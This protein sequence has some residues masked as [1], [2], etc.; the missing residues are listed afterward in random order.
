MAL[1][2]FL[3]WAVGPGPAVVIPLSDA[4]DGSCPLAWDRGVTAPVPAVPLAPSGGYLSPGAVVG[5]DGTAGGCEG[6]SFT[7]SEWA[8]GGAPWFRF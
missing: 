1:S 4:G 8:Q 7:G 3:G 5:G 6:A 2:P